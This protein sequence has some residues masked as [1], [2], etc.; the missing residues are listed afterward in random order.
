METEARQAVE[1]IENLVSRALHDAVARLAAT[2]TVMLLAG[3]CA[4]V[5][6][7]CVL[8]AL[9]LFL[10]PYLGPVGAPLAI[11]GSLLLVGLVVVALG[12]ISR[13]FQPPAPLHNVLPA[14]AVAEATNLLKDHKSSVLI[15]AVIAGLTSG[16][17]EHR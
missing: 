6:L 3:G 12:R 11:G 4:A 10:L 7:G 14:L 13:S 5:G 2:C 8:A 9:W 15:A 17:L 1:T 16:R